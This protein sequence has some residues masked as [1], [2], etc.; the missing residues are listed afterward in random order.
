MIKDRY[1]STVTKDEIIEML[2]SVKNGETVYGL[3]QARILRA[4]DEN[5]ETKGLVHI[6]DDLKDLEYILGVKFTGT[7]QLPYFGAI[8]TDEGKAWLKNE[9]KG[10]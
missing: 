7:E 3:N 9:R 1:N 2:K 6:I 4:I 10:D 5:E 8:I